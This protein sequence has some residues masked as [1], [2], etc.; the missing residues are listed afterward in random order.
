M[1]LLQLQDLTYRYKNTA[2]AVLYQINYNFEPGKFYSIIGESGAGKSTLL[3]LL[4]GLDSPVEGSILFQGED[5][6]KKGYS[7]H[8]MHHISLVFQNYNLIDYLSPLENIRLVNKKASKDTLLELGLDESQIK[9]NVLQL[10]GGQQQ[11]VAIA[12]SLVSEAP[13]ILADEPTGNLDPKT[14]GDIVELLKSLAQK[15][16][17]CVIVVTHSKEVAQASDITLELKDKKLTETRNTSK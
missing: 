7:Y 14:A 2:E 11:R 16:G 6:R 8:R 3:S 13:V 10:S 5:I 9:R 1:T 17:K 15:I 12:R 4:A